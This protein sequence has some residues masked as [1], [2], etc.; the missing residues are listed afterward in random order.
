MLYYHKII[1]ITTLTLDTQYT[2]TKFIIH[3]VQRYMVDSATHYQYADFFCQDL[4]LL[5]VSSI[6]KQ[7]CSKMQKG[8][9]SLVKRSFS[10]A[11][12]RADQVQIR[13]V[14]LA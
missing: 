13:K 12:R 4:V 10:T 2:Y 3:T 8:S 7:L 5:L 9:I 1:V 14:Q 6:L 11:L